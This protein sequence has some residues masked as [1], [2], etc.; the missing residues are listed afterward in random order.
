MP[1]LEALAQ[2]RGQLAAMVADTG[3]LKSV[4]GGGG[5]GGAWLDDPNAAWNK[6]SCNPLVV[7]ATSGYDIYI[8]LCDIYITLCVYQ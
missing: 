2:L 7:R 8:T 3:I 4:P 5:G 6:Y 1:T